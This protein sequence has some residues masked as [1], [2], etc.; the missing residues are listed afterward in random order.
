M[1]EK[2]LITELGSRKLLA[3]LAAE[4]LLIEQGTLWLDGAWYGAAGL[5]EEIRMHD[6]PVG[7]KNR[8]A[9]K[10][11]CEQ[12]RAAENGVWGVHLRPKEVWELWPKEK[13]LRLI[14]FV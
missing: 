9:L 14:N 5:K 6:I 4:Q 11:T 3:L 1:S 13:C 7:R 12:S 8:T 10:S 2:T